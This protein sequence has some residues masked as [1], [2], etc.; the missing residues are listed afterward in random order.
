MLFTGFH[1]L[2]QLP[3]KGDAILQSLIGADKSLNIDAPLRAKHKTA[4]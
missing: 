3:I 2:G 1:S 4:S